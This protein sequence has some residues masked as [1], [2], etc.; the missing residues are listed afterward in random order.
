MGVHKLP[1]SASSQVTEK[2]I[3]QR[4]HGPHVISATIDVVHYNL[5]HRISW[6]LTLPISRL[7]SVL[8]LYEY[9]MTV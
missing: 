2:R 8:F 7:L 5:S 1:H 4:Q 9:K 6:F 3:R